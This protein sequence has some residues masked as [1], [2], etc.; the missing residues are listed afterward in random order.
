MEVWDIY[1][2]DFN[3]TGKTKLRGEKLEDDEFHLVINAWICNDRGEYLISQRTANKTHPLMWECTGGSAI[4]G[5]TPLQACVREIKE[6]LGI[7]IRVDTAQFI[8]KINR[9]FLGHPDI[10][11]VYKF[12]DNSPI[13]A[14]K[15]QPE[16]VNDAMWA[17]ADTI[18]KLLKMGKF[19]ANTFMK[20]ATGIDPE[21]L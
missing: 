10:L 1:D 21:D 12:M 5:E 2:K 11:F 6:E 7:D 16:E 13:S 17:D 9:Y 15:S 20:E 3:K 19:D 8:G 18:K 4:T 14:V